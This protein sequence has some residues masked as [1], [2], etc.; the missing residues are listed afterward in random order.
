MDPQNLISRLKAKGQDLADKAENAASTVANNFNQSGN[1][2]VGGVASAVEGALSDITGSTVD[3]TKTVNG[4]TG[5]AL[6]QLDLAYG[7]LSNVLQQNMMSNPIMQG[8]SGFSSGLAG[9]TGM[10]G[11]GKQPNI[12]EGFASYN[13]VFTL[14]CLTDFELNFPD[15]TYR[16]RDPLITILKSGGGDLKGSRTVYERN[17]KTEYFIDDVEIETIV[18]GNPGTRS[19]NATSIKF[20]ITEPYS[21][22]L[23]LQALQIAALSAGHKNY[24]EAPYVLSV[25]FKGYDQAG[26]RYTARQGRRIFPLKFVNVEFEVTE[27]G[28]MYAVQAIPFH[29]EALKDQMQTTRTDITFHGRT[30]SE[31]LQWGFQSLTNNMNEK[32][33][34]GEK[35]GN[36]TKADQYIILFP[37]ENSSAKESAAFSKV[38]SSG[39]DSATTAGNNG[40]QEGQEQRE[41]TEEQLQRLYESATGVLNGKMTMKEFESK[42][43][44]EKG[45]I[46]KRSSLGETIREYA[47]KEENINSIGMSKI[48]KS[49]LDTGKKPFGKK[50]DCEDENVKGKIDRCKVVPS[51]DARIMSVSSGKKLQDIIEEVILLSEYGR[52]ITERKPDTNGM[53]DWFRIETNVYQVTSH[54]NVDQTGKPPRIFVF[55]VVPYK[56]HHSKFRS[57]TEKSKGIQNIKNIAAKEYNYIYTGQNKD[58]INFDINFNHAFFTSIAGDFGQKTA[59]S[60]TSE[61][62]AKAAGNKVASPGAT[63]GDTNST[64]NSKTNASINTGNPTDGGGPMVHPES[65]VARNFNEALMNSPVDLVMLDLEIWGDPYYIGDSGMGNYSAAPGPSFNITSDG[66][67]DYQNGEVDIEI[68]FRTPID[69]AGNYMEFPGGGYGPVGAF[70]GLYQVLFCNNKFSKGQFTQT[71]QTIRRPKQES[72]TKQVAADATGAV[73]TKEENKQISTTESKTEG[74]KDSQNGPPPGHPEYNQGANTSPSKQPSSGFIK[75][76]NARRMPDGRIVGGL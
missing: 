63:T 64:E 54:E 28:S 13:Y 38:Q 6:G 76:T 50:K 60:L 30:V 51:D 22:G 35:V 45:I 27:G 74:G 21:M 8:I 9:L 36:A 52:G 31:M 58:I 3:M 7:G 57:P 18:A 15:L 40:S 39:G 20:Q 44:E 72:D 10:F 24:I 23:F 66:S 43:A 33:L 14:G 34:E 61:S 65:I 16:Y 42:L 70:S 73:T 29:E 56:V 25:E 19:T 5:P 55:R 11:L 46:L 32:L 2:S 67:M 62:G 41:L 17:G 49:R 26:R 4:I 47:D 37:T 71:L 48:V 1:I 12:L 69:Y 53:L 68:N 75:G 59:D